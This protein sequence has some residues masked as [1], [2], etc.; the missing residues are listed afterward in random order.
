VTLEFK[1]V[2]IGSRLDPSCDLLAAM[3]FCECGCNQWMIFSLNG[4][5]H[6]HLECAMCGMSYCPQGKCTIPESRGK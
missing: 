5:D 6:W 1:M 3:P 2:H 4:T